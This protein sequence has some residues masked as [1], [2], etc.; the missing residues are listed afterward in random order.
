MGVNFLPRSLAARS[1]SC[2]RSSRRLRKSRKD[3]CS[4]AS[5]GLASPPDQS[6]SQRTST[7]ERSVVSVSM[8]LGGERLG[9]TEKITD[10]LWG[11][12]AFDRVTAKVSQRGVVEVGLDQRVLGEEDLLNG[13][14]KAYLLGVVVVSLNVPLEAALHQLRVIGD[15]IEGQ[16]VAE[17][18]EEVVHA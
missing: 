16:Q 15:G 6:L 1:A 10:F 2:S 7:A 14:K 8:V 12:E 3:S 13:P 17:E 11:E 9:E 4:M 5:R 18:S